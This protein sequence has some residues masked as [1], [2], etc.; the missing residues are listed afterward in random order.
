[1]VTKLVDDTNLLW[2]VKMSATGEAATGLEA[3]SKLG[4]NEDQQEQ[5]CTVKQLLLK[6][7]MTPVSGLFWAFFLYLIWTS[8]SLPI[9]INRMSADGALK[10]HFWSLSFGLITSERSPVHVLSD[11]LQCVQMHGKWR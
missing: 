2:I 4:R 10:L 9:S 1:M 3:M 7:H 6:T 11:H 8:S 5:I